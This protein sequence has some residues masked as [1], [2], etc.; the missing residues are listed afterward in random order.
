MYIMKTQNTSRFFTLISHVFLF[1]FYDN[2]LVDPIHLNEYL[3]HSNR[4]KDRTEMLKNTL[5]KLLDS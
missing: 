4:S 5:L 2:H 1:F 3:S